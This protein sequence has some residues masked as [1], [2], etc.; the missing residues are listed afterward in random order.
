[1][2]NELFYYLKKFDLEK[3][4]KNEFFNKLYLKHFEKGEMIFSVE[5]ESQS[6]YFLVEGK[7]KVYSAFYGKK[8][9]IIEFC[10]PMQILG[11]IEYI[12]NK[13]INTNVEALTPCIVI[14]IL[15]TDFKNLIIQNDNLYELLLKSISDKLAN[16]MNHVLSY[17]QEP[18][19]DRALKYLKELS[20]DKKIE[21]IKYIEMA[22]YLNISDRYLRKLLKELVDNN[23]IIKNGKSIEIL[24]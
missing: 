20:K 2:K 22:E 8:E 7:I 1:M 21:K 14:G 11:E 6:I 23:I 12:Q 4:I 3:C 10:R 13:T 5:E 15:K 18:L 24:K 17:H 16:T 19:K 9:V